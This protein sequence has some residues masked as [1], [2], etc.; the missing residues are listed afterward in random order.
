MSGQVAESLAADWG[1]SRFRLWALRGGRVIG[2][3]ENDNG[4][5]KMTKAADYESALL[6]AAAPWLPKAATATTKG[7]ANDGKIAVRICGMAG[8]RDGWRQ[9]PY[10]FVPCPPLAVNDASAKVP[11]RDSRIAVFIVPG[12]AQR[13]PCNVM[14]GEETQIAGLIAADAGF[15]GAVC[16]PGSHAKWA[17]VKGGMVRRF[18]TMMTGEV[19]A[20]LSQHSA[21]RH[22]INNFGKK[23]ID[24]DSFDESAFMDAAAEVMR[25]PSVMA[26]KLFSVRAES[27]LK[28]MPPKTARARLSGFC[29]GADIAAAANYWRNGKVAIIGAGGIGKLYQTAMKLRGIKADIINGKKAALAGLQTIA[30]G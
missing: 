25:R 17:R 14:R 22:C 27:I 18:S 9:T 21:L 30:A 4:A 10:R 8:A 19:Y 11:V 5:A 28:N 26:S 13:H 6:K 23:G 24:K 16:L 1:L 29:I 7:K 2:E 3:V 12:L 20:L 15:D